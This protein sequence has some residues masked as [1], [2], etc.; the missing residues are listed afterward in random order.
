MQALTFQYPAAEGRVSVVIPTRNGDKY[1]GAALDSVAA[2]AHGD[3]E[4]IVIEDGS[5]GETQSI[6]QRFA[7]RCPGRRVCY[8]RNEQSLGAAAT[9]NLAFELAKGEYVA[10]LDCD[11]LWLPTHLR[12]CVG[13]LRD[14]GDDVAYS[15]AAMFEDGSDQMIGFWGP[16]REEVLRFPHSLLGRNFVTPSATVL[17]RSVLAEAGRWNTTFR[18]CEDAEFFFRVA[19]L[20]KRFRCVGG[21]HCLYRKQHDGATTQRIAGT[22]EEFATLTSWNLDMPGGAPG[23]AA[24]LSARAHAVSAKLHAK[25]HPTADPSANRSRAAPL[26][27][28]AWRLRPLQ[29][30]YLFQTLRHAATKGWTASERLPLPHGQQTLPAAA[31]RAAA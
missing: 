18:Y 3:W 26:F 28:A 5:Q 8:S 19:K 10:F 16:S 24:R 15:A 22:T 14:S 9:R 4:V 13:A 25:N 12:A 1:I 21:V 6:V 31:P 11:D 23:E 27:F 2:Q 7:S 17:R 29:I 20:G 30:D